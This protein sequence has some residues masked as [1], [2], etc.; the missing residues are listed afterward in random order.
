MLGVQVVYYLKV[1][2]STLHKKSN[3]FKI[4]FKPVQRKTGFTCIV[5]STLS[6]LR[7][8]KLSL[9]LQTSS[10]NHMLEIICDSIS[11]SVLHLFDSQL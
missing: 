1:C 10:D 6:F 4:V 9:R 3:R 2:L 7:E 5:V 8:E 11:I